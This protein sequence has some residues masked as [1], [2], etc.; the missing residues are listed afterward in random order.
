MTRLAYFNLVRLLHCSIRDA[1]VP[2]EIAGEFSMIVKIAFTSLSVLVLSALGVSANATTNL[3]TNGSF[4]NYTSS[5]TSN[6]MVNVGAS[7]GDV[8]TDWATT[9]NYTFLLTP[10]LATENGTTGDTQTLNGPDG[11]L[12]FYFGTNPQFSASPDGGNFLASDGAYETGTISQ[13][14]AGLTVGNSYAVSFY[15]AG[16]QQAGFTGP[17]TDQWE[18]SLGSQTDYSSV[19]SD[20]SATFSG[21][22]QQTLYFTATSTSETLSFFAIGTPS[23]VPPFALLDGVSIVQ[24]PEPAT[25]TVMIAGL[26][27]VAGARRWSRSRRS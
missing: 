22:Q 3:I 8:L 12:S 15:Q 21:W 2:R 14:I 4:T 26:L 18:V 10:Q 25:W 13:T 6:E 27:G 11:A 1:A 17:T 19:I 24:A 20:A 23:G 16:A 9:S 5:G 7:S